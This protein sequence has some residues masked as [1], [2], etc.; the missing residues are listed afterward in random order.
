MEAETFARRVFVE[1]IG[2]E[3]VI[4][5]HNCR[6]GRGRSGGYDFLVEH[7][8]D[9][10]FE[11]RECP[12]IRIGDQNVSSTDIRRA[13]LDGDLDRAA[14]MLGRPY[15]IWGTVVEGHRRGRTIG[16]PTANLDLHHELRP[17]RG[18][19]GCRVDV[20]GTTYD[21]LTNIGVRPTFAKPE[22]WEDRDRNE[23]IEVHLL[24][25]EGDLY[26]R[27]LEVTFLDRIRSERRFESV[28][29]LVAQ[30]GRDRETFLAYLRDPNS[31]TSS[32]EPGH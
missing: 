16:F 22:T 14:S 29:A 31:P 1:A 10:A 32:G 6:F 18:V 12:E 13:I 30:I 23:S 21:A 20:D 5:G 2:A 7:A 24:E 11:T 3:L 15:S 17:P 25:F 26:G 4:L 28:D 19:Y 27:D 9:Y 8:D